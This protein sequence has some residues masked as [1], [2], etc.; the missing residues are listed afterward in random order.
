RSAGC[1]AP[2]NGTARRPATS[3]AGPSRVD[4]AAPSRGRRTFRVA[5]ASA[6]GPRARS[7]LPALGT[8]LAGIPPHRSKAAHL[9]VVGRGR[10]ARG[11]ARGRLLP[12]PTFSTGGDKQRFFE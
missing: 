7:P 10:L 4:P 8:D 2:P 6:R 11:E 3:S 1:W 9:I 12:S 5:G